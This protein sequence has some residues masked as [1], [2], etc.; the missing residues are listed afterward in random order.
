MRKNQNSSVPIRET[1]ENQS[2][3]RLRFTSCFIALLLSSLMAVARHSSNPTF[4]AVGKTIEYIALVVT[5]C[6]IMWWWLLRM[7]EM[8]FPHSD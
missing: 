4:H 3:L 8:F 2:R 7:K 5:I 1:M 6:V